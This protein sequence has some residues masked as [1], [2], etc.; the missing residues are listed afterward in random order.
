MK[1]QGRKAISS[2]TLLTV[3]SMQI[4]MGGEWMIQILITELG[5]SETGP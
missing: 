5:W 2:C 3:I 4:K 1:D